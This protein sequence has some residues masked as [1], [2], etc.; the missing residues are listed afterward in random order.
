L[1]VLRPVGNCVPSLRCRCQ[2]RFC[3]LGALGFPERQWRLLAGGRGRVD[4]AVEVDGADRMLVIIEI[5][6]TDWDKI[7]AAR[8]MRNLRR[9][10]HQLQGYLDT[11]I[12]EMETGD[13]TGIIGS[14]L[15]P[16]RPASSETLAT[17]AAVAGEEAIMVTWYE[18]VDWHRPACLSIAVRA[19]QRTD[20]P[21]IAHLFL[22][23]RR[24]RKRRTGM[25]K[26]LA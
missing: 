5:K 12:E 10:L 24:I 19:R 22:V 7:P 16:A 6:G 11:S 17:I 15:Y 9:H 26:G 2:F 4:L 8:L 3:V 21:Q 1:V 25:A 23:L 13:W 18:D 14:L 20:R